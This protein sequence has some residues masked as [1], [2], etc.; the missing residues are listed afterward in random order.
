MGEENGGVLLKGDGA[1][2]GHRVQGIWTALENFFTGLIWNIAP[3][4]MGM[5]G[6]EHD[7]T[8]KTGFAK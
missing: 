1:G 2:E 7:I 3:M 5:F 8:E 6:M 4:V